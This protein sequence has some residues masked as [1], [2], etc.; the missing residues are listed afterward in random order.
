MGT[1]PVLGALFDTGKIPTIALCNQAKTPLG[2]GLPQLCTALQAFLDSYLSPIWGPRARL[3][4]KTQ[5]D[6]GDWGLLLLDSTDQAG[7]LGY[8][9]L[10]K[11]G[12]PQGLVFVQTVMQYH[13]QLSVTL[14]HELAE[15]LVNPGCQL[16]AEDDQGVG[17]ALEACDPCQANTFLLQG[18]A[19]S[20]FV[21]P[22][23][24]Q[25]WRT[26]Q[27]TPFDLLGI[28]QQPLTLAPGGYMNVKKAG[29]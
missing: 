8:H 13:E 27:Q 28:I 7:A 9:S 19:M 14:C 26:R 2:L 21:L 22:S 10:T 24:F 11:D 5:P 1:K 12:F 15:L 6:P 29:R 25:D 23:W 20:D 4:L 17:Y 16:L 3:Q 18:F